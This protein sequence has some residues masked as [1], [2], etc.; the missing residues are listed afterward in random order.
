VY[1]QVNPVVNFEILDVT[2]PADTRKAV[3]TF[4]MTDDKGRPH[5][6]L[7]VYSQYAAAPAFILAVLDPTTNQYN[8]YTRS[9]RNAAQGGTDSGGTLEWVEGGTYT[10]TFGTAA[11]EGYDVTATHTVGGYARITRED[12]V[13]VA[14]N[15]TFD[16]VPNGDAVTQI[17]QYAVIE[18]CNACHGDLAFHGGSRRQIE[19]CNL[20]HN[21][22]TADN[23]ATG[24]SVALMPMV[25]KLHM[26]SNLPSVAA[27]GT[28][29]IASH[30]YTNI[31]FPQRNSNCE[32]CHTVA[33]TLTVEGIVNRDTCGSCHDL[34]WFGPAAD[35]VDP[36]TAH[37]GGPQATDANCTSCHTP[38][39]LSDQVAKHLDPADDTA[40]PGL[41]VE[42]VSATY[43]AGSL[44][45]VVFS[46]KN[47][48]TNVALLT[49][50]LGGNGSISVVFSGPLP[51]ITT[52]KSYNVKSTGTLVADGTNFRYTPPAPGADAAAIELADAGSLRVSMEGY[53]RTGST[54]PRFQT[55]NPV[56]DVAVTDGTLTA[57]RT[58]VDVDNC[59][60]CHKQL[61][62]HGGQH[63]NP[64]HCVACHNPNNQNDERVALPPVG[65]TVVP[66]SVDLK[67]MVH[68]IHMGKELENDYIL[69]GYGRTVLDFSH[70]TSPNSPGNCTSCHEGTS[71]T[72]PLKAEVIGTRYA[73]V[74]RTVGADGLFGPQPGP[75][76]ILGNMDDVLDDKTAEVFGTDFRVPPTTSVCTSCHDGEST[77]IHA[78]LQTG[79]AGESCATCHGSGK[80]FD[81]A[82]VHPIR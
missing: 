75:D 51:E 27:G 50:D 53:F 11:P 63:N 36:F 55:V 31:V 68:K 22:G 74:E 37:A 21:P 80:E 77:W 24:N 76:G 14:G 56:L 10:Y 81:V 67:V 40:N 15:D 42:I 45:T 13:R 52:Y 48:G 3:V 28:Y 20:C 1:Y 44:P 70:G 54:G 65:E 4:S 79:T 46:V 6:A 60:S 35:R 19:V 59:N 61:G 82:K 12:G 78:E 26:G 71:Y 2:L 58:V 23:A 29:G 18:S 66:H 32:K 69:G 7:G 73:E 30:D 49:D 43:A 33:D 41:E 25:H 16:F 39:G 17:R 9:T 62:L 57:R 64:N 8:A 5:D 47:R 38:G 34:T 72:L